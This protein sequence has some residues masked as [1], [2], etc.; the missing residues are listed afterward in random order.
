ELGVH[1]SNGYFGIDTIF[2]QERDTIDFPNSKFTWAKYISVA[3]EHENEYQEVAEEMNRLQIYNVPLCGADNLSP[4]G[5]T[6]RKTAS[7][8][9]RDSSGS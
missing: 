6:R 8:I 9:C 7:E 4:N 1:H 2:Y 3:F 5:G